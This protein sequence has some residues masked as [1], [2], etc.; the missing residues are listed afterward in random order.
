MQR[1]L[2]TI[3]SLSLVGCSVLFVRG[4]SDPPPIRGVPAPM[5]PSCDEG[6]A[7][8]YIDA[9]I[10]ALYL[11]VA[12]I[13]ISDKG[14][15]GTTNNGDDSQAGAAIAGLVVG[16]L[17]GGSAY[18]GFSRT[19]ACHERRMQ[20]MQTY[21]NQYYMPQ[22]AYYP[23]QQPASEGQTC[24][25]QLGCLQGL[26]CASNLCVRPP[27]PPLPPAPPP[28]TVPIPPAPPTP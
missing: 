20:F 11:L 16:G 13:A 24:H 10:A 12:V 2:A 26:V 7:M 5:Y 17:F 8:P 4:P 14:S 18:V 27:L 1:L 19:S 15:L 6:Q 22:P 28:V 25:P 9:S 23:P 3:A 21:G